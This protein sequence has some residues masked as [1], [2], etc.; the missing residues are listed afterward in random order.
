MLRVS[1]TDVRE[2]A[3]QDAIARNSEDIIW[4]PK[5]GFEGWRVGGY[6]VRRVIICGPFPPDSSALGYDFDSLKI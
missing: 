4:S 5:L 2:E 3:Y 6:A 1:E